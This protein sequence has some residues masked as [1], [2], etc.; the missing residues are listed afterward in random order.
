MV[1]HMQVYVAHYQHGKR[2]K[3]GTSSIIVP[4]MFYAAMGGT[5]DGGS[6]LQSCLHMP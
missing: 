1:L 4:A 5:K 6:S 3:H 2:Y